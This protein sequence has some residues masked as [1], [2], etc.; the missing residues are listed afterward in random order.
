MREL[1]NEEK[2]KKGGKGERAEKI[3][4]GVWGPQNSTGNPGTKAKEKGKNKTGIKMKVNR[5]EPGLRW[6]MVRG[7]LKD[8]R[9]E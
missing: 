9:G 8:H 5:E 2:K 1:K 7:G 3:K 4:K 6:T